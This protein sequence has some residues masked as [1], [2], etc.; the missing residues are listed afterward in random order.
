MRVRE[1]PLGRS[2]GPKPNRFMSVT[3][4]SSTNP[5]STLYGQDS[6]AAALPTQTL[7]QK[8]FLK[9]L[10]AQMSSQDPL[11]PMTNNDFMAQMAQ[12]STLQQTEAMQ[13]DIAQIR[14]SQSLSQASSLLGRT[15]QVQPGQGLPVTGVVTAVTVQAGTPILIVNGQ[16]YGLSQVLSVSQAQPTA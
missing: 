14:S 13:K 11:N 4:A 6:Q 15:V 10:V 9:L 16:Q 8:D 12:F 3:S 1:Q 7:D 2:G 5:V